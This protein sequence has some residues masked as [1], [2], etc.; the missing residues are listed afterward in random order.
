MEWNGLEQNEM[1][2]IQLSGNKIY[3]YARTTGQQ[4]EHNKSLCVNMMDVI[5]IVWR[6][7][8]ATCAPL[9]KMY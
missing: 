8:T 5:P 2:P 7:T 3:L 1:K 6:K 4:E 9:V